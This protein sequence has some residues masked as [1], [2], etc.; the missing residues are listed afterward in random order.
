MM[1]IDQ[2]TG[3]TVYG[4]D[5]LSCRVKRVLSTKVGS[6]VKRRAVGNRA[7]DRLGKNQN[8][9]EA[10]IVQNLSIEALT[11]THNQFDGLTI[12]QC[13]AKP[14]GAGFVVSIIGAWKGEPLKLSI[15]V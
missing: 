11:N 12:E 14:N 7:I 5:A 1:A 3:F 4:L 2:D 6:R 10:L 15:T 13:I 9:S 8:P